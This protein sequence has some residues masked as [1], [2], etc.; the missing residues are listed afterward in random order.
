MDK[1]YRTQI[2]RAMELL[3]RTVNNEDVFE[4]WLLCGVADGDIDENTTDEELEYYTEDSTFADIM[5]TFLRVMHGAYHDG[6]LYA[7][8]VSDE[9]DE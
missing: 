5:H 7:D 9:E 3:A 1:A 8:G 4:R 2:V 6:G